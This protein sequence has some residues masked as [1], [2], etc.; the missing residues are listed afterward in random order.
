MQ[1]D[2]QFLSG[3]LEFHRSVSVPDDPG[4]GSRSQSQANQGILRRVSRPDIFEGES[5]YLKAL[6]CGSV[7]K[8]V[9]FGS[10]N[11]LEFHGFRLWFAM[12]PTYN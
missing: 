12:P 8:L 7:V 9:P 11:A 2:F 6:V 4:F 5:E 10:E 3:R 1:R